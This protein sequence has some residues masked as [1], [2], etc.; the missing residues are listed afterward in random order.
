MEV[1]SVLKDR[2]VLESVIG[3]G[4]MGVVFKA[5]DLRREEA[6][7]RNPYIA[8]KILNDEFR[9]HPESLKALQRESRKA[10]DLAHPN[11]VTVFDFDRDGAIVY[12][13]MEYLEGYSLDKCFKDPSF[14]G[15]PLSEAYPLIAGLGSALS[16]AH[17]KGIVHSDF[18]PGNTFLTNEGEIK[19]FDFGIARAAKLPGD[20]SGEMTLFDPGS[21]GA[22]TPAY[23]SREMIEGEEPDPRDDTLSTSARHPRLTT[24]GLSRRRSRA[25]ADAIGGAC[26]ADWRSIAVTD[27]Q[28]CRNL[29][30]T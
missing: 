9:R 25:L 21:L 4:G 19:V 30:M 15:M 22:L 14:D 12:M 5:R 7:D 16:Y 3:R 23:A 24:R 10:Q 17:D 28:T 1:G 6:Q 8:V 13:T 29:L 2:Y 11:I 20:K 18:K 26:S 27:R